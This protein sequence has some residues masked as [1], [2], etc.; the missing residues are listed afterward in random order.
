MW[1]TFFFFPFIYQGWIVFLITFFIFRLFFSFHFFVVGRCDLFFFLLLLKVLNP[2]CRSNENTVFFLF[3]FRIISSLTECCIFVHNHVYFTLQLIL[4]SIKSQFFGRF[5]HFF[6]VL[7]ISLFIDLFL[8]YAAPVTE[9]KM[10][11]REQML[12]GVYSFV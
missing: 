10:S 5:K 1:I 12:T 4:F 2:H 6:F 7:L 9:E 3:V 8:R 11:H